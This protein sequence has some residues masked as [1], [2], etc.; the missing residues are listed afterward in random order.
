MLIIDAHL[1]LAWNALQWNRNLQESVYTI[2]EQESNL[3]GPG[4]RQGTVA[5]PEMRKGRVA[6]CFAT[7]L[8]RSTGRAEP[9]LDYSSP[10]QACAVAQGQLAYYQ[11]LSELGEVRL[12]KDIA[13]LNDHF[14][15][16]EQWENNTQITQPPL[17]LIISME[18][19]DPILKPDQLSAWKE[20]GVRII[21]PAH[22]GPGRYAGGTSTE[23]GLTSDGFTLLHEMERLGII[24]DLTHLSDEAFW[25]ALD[26]FGGYMIASHNNCRALVPHQRQF[27]DKQIKA[28]L[29]RQGVIGAAL[30]NWMLIPDW[31][32]GANDNQPTTL[33]HVADHIDYICQLAG[34]AKHVAIGSD[35]DGG[36]GRE[37]SPSDLDTIADLQKLGE[38]LA[39]RGYNTEVVLSI[40]HGNWLRLLRNAWVG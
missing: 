22:Y 32:R 38:I 20:A 26:H 17:G 30:D 39:K 8:A 11:A 4:R 7:V 9:Y 37:Q 10:L 40:M 14:A 34:N 18:S 31:V 29:A 2:R 27:D 25:Q 15:E 35:L 36:F 28:I 23:L 16:W 19:A 1:D 6:V 13:G 24:L 12:I 21:G 3:S 33:E 5:L